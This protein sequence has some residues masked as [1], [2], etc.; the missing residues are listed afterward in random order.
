MNAQGIILVSSPSAVIYY[1]TFDSPAGPP[2]P[3]AHSRGEL[4]VYYFADSRKNSTEG[5]GA[6]GGEELR[7][8]GTR[9]DIVVGK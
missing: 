7:M 9:S 2:R 8:E 3:K 6:G 1:F 4:S 5:G